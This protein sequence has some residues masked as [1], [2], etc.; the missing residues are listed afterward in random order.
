MNESLR[1]WIVVVGGLAAGTA[2]AS[3]VV[4]VRTYRDQVRRQRTQWV[5]DLR[6]R[7]VDTEAMR[8]AWQEM[9]QAAISG[10][11]VAITAIE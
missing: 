10:H 1:S 8:R 6:N 7:F 11:G 9:Q 4:A 3:L 2:V 5:I